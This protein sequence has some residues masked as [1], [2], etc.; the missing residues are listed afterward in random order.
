MAQRDR[1][2]ARAAAARCWRWRRWR[3][4]PT[5]A[6][7]SMPRRPTGSICRST[8]SRRWRGDP[9]LAGWDGLGLAVQAYQKRALPLIDWLA[10][11]GAAPRPPHDGA[12][13]EGRLLGQR[14]QAG[15]GARPRRLSGLHPQGRDRRLLSRLRQAAARPAPSASIRSSPRTTRT[16]VAAVLEMAG[17]RARFEFQRL[18][19]MGEALYDQVVGAR[20][21][22]IA[23]PRLCAG[24]QPRGPARLSGAAAAG[25]RRQHLL[26]QPPRRR[27]AP[28]DEIVADPVARLARAAGTSRI[29]A[30]RCRATLFGRSGAIRAASI[31]T[32]PRRAGAAAD[33]DGERRG[34]AA[35]TAAPIVGGAAEAGAAR[36]GARSRR[37]PPASSARSPTPRP[38]RSTQALARAARRAAGLGR[39]PA[40]ERARDAWN[41]PPICCEARSRRADGAGRAR[42]RQDPARRAVA[43][44]A[45]RSIS[46]ATTPRARAPISPR[47]RRCPGRPASA[48]SSRCTGAA[49]SPASAPW[50]FPLA[51][52]TGQ[53]A[54]ALAAGNAVLAKPA[55]QT[56]LIAAAAVR[57]LHEAGVPGDVLHL[58]PGDGADGRRGAGRRSAHRRRRLHRLDRDRPGDQPRAGRTR[59]PD[60]A[61]DRRDR[62]PERDDRRFHRR[63]PS[64]WCAMSSPRPSTAPASAARRCACSSCRRTSPTR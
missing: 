11:S 17:D 56:P 15:A 61:A 20:R 1:V 7:P 9:E 33:G 55:E 34:G 46:C 38:M 10:R 57:L 60:R 26:R 12:A 16:R 3:A 4:T 27:E 2:H 37:P 49:S 28:I 44:C 25:E 39:T 22:G 29:R 21:R 24:R 14:D 59:R 19:G 53:V 47:R 36:A 64:R 18:H 6:S 13:G 48:T 35:G 30:F 32:D 41:A 50:N 42:G 52:F 8:S 40:R 43:K 5:S 58:L 62:R 23:L 63:C 45:R 31:S 54:A 51:I